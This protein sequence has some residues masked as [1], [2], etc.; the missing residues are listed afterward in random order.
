MPT[1][2][3]ITASQSDSEISSSASIYNSSAMTNGNYPGNSMVINSAGNAP[4]K[5][6]YDFKID[7]VT[8]GKTFLWTTISDESFYV[9][10][11]I[12]NGTDLLANSIEL[13]EGETLRNVQFV[14]SKDVGTLKGTVLDGEKQPVRKAEFS[15]ISVDG[16]KRKNPFLSRSVTTK[17]NGEFEV[18]AA[19]G[20]YAIVF[21]NKEF[22]GKK[23]EE[24]D[25]LLD[26]AVKNSVK[27]TLKP[28]ETEK[29]SLVLP[30]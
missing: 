30:K 29:V 21:Y 22:S 11:A 9:K 20:E 17:E 3:V 10:S 2:I 7:G 1:N 24:L 18:K 19:P 4:R 5:P 23:G 13:K 15:L 27:V 14:I 6:N 12:F 25:Q 26:E 28:K 16:A 8:T